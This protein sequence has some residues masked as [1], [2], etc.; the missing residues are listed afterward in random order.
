MNGIKILFV[1]AAVFFAPLFIFFFLIWVDVNPSGR[2]V[3]EE[4]VGSLS[5]YL[6]RFLPET[7]VLG[8]QSGEDGPFQSVV[9]EP[10]YLSV[11]PPG[12]YQSVTLEILF[13]NTEQPIIELGLLVQEDPRQQILKPA[14]NLLIDQS[15]WRRLEREDG[16]ILLQREMIYDSIEVFELDPPARNSVAVY[17]YQLVEP[18]REAGYRPADALTTYDVTLRGYHEYVTYI[19]NEPLLLQTSFMDMNRAAGGD[20]VE[21]LAVNETGEIV[22]SAVVADDGRD[23][24]EQSASEPRAAALIISDLPEGVYKVILKAGRDIFFRSLTTRQRYLT[25]V[26]PV[27]FGDEAGY[28]DESRPVSFWTDGKLLSFETYH[29]DASQRVQIGQEEL[30]MPETQL[31]Y[32]FIVEE[33]DLAPIIAPAGDLLFTSEGKVSLTKAAF[34]NPDPIRLTWNTDLEASGV[35][36]IIARYQ[37]PEIDRAWKVAGATF[38]LTDRRDASSPLKFVLAAPGITALQNEFRIHGFRLTFERPAISLL[39]ALKKFFL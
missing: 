3:I 21:F 38:N 9:G 27:F 30:L 15:E 18:Y 25:F 5:P 8:V 36:F 14:E 13:Q 16:T 1:K 11:Y 17:N 26:G 6:D 39:T 37:K 33:A 31:R 35:N 32:D 34:F 10:T 12:D 24:A 23:E 19:K 28:Q 2:F 7:R 22:G 20:P 29:A 4:K